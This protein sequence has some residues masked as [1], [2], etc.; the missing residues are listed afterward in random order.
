MVAV[1]LSICDT[2]AIKPGNVLGLF[3]LLTS[4]VTLGKSP[5]LSEPQFHLSRRLVSYRVAQGRCSSSGRGLP[6][7]SAH[8]GWQPGN[9]L[10]PGSEGRSELLTP[11]PRGRKLAE[12]ASSYSSAPSDGKGTGGSGPA[13]PRVSSERHHRQ[14]SA[15]GLPGPGWLAKIKPTANEAPFEALG[16]KPARALGFPATRGKA[17]PWLVDI[18]RQSSPQ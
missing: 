15:E 2:T 8:R 4:S 12:G 1:G 3:S 10:R 9:G 11:T 6:Q 5:D 13:Q 17:A 14:P 18:P 7:P 16:I